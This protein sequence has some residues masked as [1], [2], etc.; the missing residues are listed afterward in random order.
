MGVSIE[1][2]ELS[3]G[4]AD[5]SSARVHPAAALSRLYRAVAYSAAPGRPAGLPITV[6]RL[7]RCAAFLETFR[8][9]YSGSAD[10]ALREMLAWRPTLVN[11]AIWPYMNVRWPASRRLA[12]T[13]EHYELLNGELEFLRF[14][15]TGFVALAELMGDIQVR[16]EKS[17]WLHHEGEIAIS[18]F[19]Q[20]RRI[21]TLSFTLGRFR[22]ERL[23]YVGALQGISD[24]DALDIYRWLTRLMYGLRPRDLLVH[25]FQMLCGPLGV[26]RILAVD[27][28]SSICR[29]AFYGTR[30]Q[31]FC[32]YDDAWREHGGLP[33]PGGFFELDVG[34]VARPLEVAPS[35][36][37]AQYR[38][39]HKLLAG[40]FEQIVEA[41]QFAGATAARFQV[42]PA[43]DG[44]LGVPPTDDGARAQVLAD[45]EFAAIAETFRSAK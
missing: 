35:R 22:E 8:H 42:Q 17:S 37:R 28:H 1:A 30:S 32:S 34:L 31:V 27:D 11:R 13:S 25:S 12:V 9:W 43:G 18:L 3:R 2:Q 38:R 7:V 39:R 6:M 5:Q 26:D 4:M 21:Y 45:S 44:T 36:K 41:V 10:P 23:A 33:V 16:L 24:D 14:A 40:L 19:R 15:P 20:N 29:S